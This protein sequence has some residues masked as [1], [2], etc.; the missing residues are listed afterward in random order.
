MEKKRKKKDGV[1]FSSFS[2]LYFTFSYSYYYCFYF[3]SYSFSSSSSSSLDRSVLSKT[4]SKRIVLAKIYSETSTM[5]NH[6]RTVLDR[7]WWWIDIDTFS[8]LNHHL[9]LFFRQL[10]VVFARVRVIL[11]AYE[12]SSNSTIRHRS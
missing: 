2:S 8:R 11:I 6:D 9:G 3:S 5:Q 7:F 10:F 12:T 4:Y 1:F